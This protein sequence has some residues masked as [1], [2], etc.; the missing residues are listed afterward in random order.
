[1]GS[2][3]AISI[4]KIKA[5]SELLVLNS[6]VLRVIKENNNLVYKKIRQ[7]TNLKEVHKLKRFDFALD[8]ILWTR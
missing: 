3:K 8:K 1:M 4:S 5:D 7:S 6:T 2:N